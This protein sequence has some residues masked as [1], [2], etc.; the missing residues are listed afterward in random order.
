M[1]YLEAAPEPL[2]R[3]PSD[4]SCCV[5]WAV[6]CAILAVW[7]M[8]HGGEPRIWLAI[9][10]VAFI[11]IRS[12][13]PELLHAAN[14]A[15]FRLSLLWG[16]IMTPIMAGL[17]YY[18]LFTPIG[19]LRRCFRMSAVNLRADPRAATYWVTRPPAASTKQD[20]LRQF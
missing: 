8:L 5:S 1:H 11:T 2:R 4:S 19:A 10:S 3:I 7:P 13:R 6:V 12:L 17:L 18:V 20:M 14:V 15:V 16:R 9:L